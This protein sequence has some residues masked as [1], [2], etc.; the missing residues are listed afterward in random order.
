MS[1]VWSH[2]RIRTRYLA[3]ALLILFIPS[4]RA[5][6]LERLCDS[7]FTNCRTEVLERI[8]AEHVGIDVAAWFFEDSRFSNELIKRWQAGVRVRVVIDPRANVQHPVNGPILD[9]MAAAGIP[10]RHRIAKGIEHWKLMLFAGQDVAYFGSAN[11]S[12]DAFVPWDPYKN[13]VDETIYG[14]DD[15]DFVNT[16]KTKF[17]ETWI[18]TSSYANYGNAPNSSLTRSYPIYPT[19]PELNFAP[20]SGSSSFRSRSVSRYNAETQ[21]IDIVMY[22]ITDQAHVDAI[23]SAYR[24]GVRVRLLTEQQMYRDV[25]KLWHSMSV[26]KMYAAGI[27]IKHR[28]HAGQNHQKTVLLYGQR[29]SIFGSSNWTSSSSDSQ[30]EHNYF[31]TKAHIFQW[32]VN[33]FE[34]KWNNTNPLGAPESGPFVPLPPD[35]P[36][37]ISPAD[38]YVG[39]ATSGARLRWYGGPWAHLYDIYFGTTP[40]PPLFASNQALGPSET[41]TQN[42]SF[43]LPAL[44]PGTTYYWTIVS[45]TMANRTRAGNVWSFTTAGSPP[46]PPAGA[47]TVVL[48]PSNAPASAIRGDWRVGPDSGAGGASIWNPDRGRAKVSPAL[49]SPA[50][51]FEMTFNALGG[52]AYHLWIRM[53]AQGN[54]LGNDSVHIQFSDSVDGAGTPFARIG[55]EGS[56]EL[57]LQAGPGGA[58]PQSWGWTDNGWGSLGPH[59]YFATS[60]SHVVRVQQRE[61]GA[62][63]D[64]IVLSPSMYISLPPGGR[65][66]DTTILP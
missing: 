18:N 1:C 60:G 63:I 65:L 5:Q 34:R 37:Y 53:R 39:V 10:M 57:V 51:Y 21:K 7:S 8:R 23:I 52:V 45:K 58:V 24:R 27:P 12:A 4:A 30:H 54:S 59:I 55:T 44:A 42:Q 2:C 17:D 11:F 35:K 31:T 16:F 33:Q 29:M 41:T 14:T 61:D 3:V 43:T 25:G 13:Y 20:A 26:D 64:Q 32:F 6:G 66:N 28:A 36:V 38:A 19:D 62:I 40:T 56:A 15:P 9:Q 48:W 49:R 47:T 50:N 46:P 22:R